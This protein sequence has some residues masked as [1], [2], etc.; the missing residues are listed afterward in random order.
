MSALAWTE[1]VMFA[2]AIVLLIWAWVLRE[3]AKVE[4][5]IA[6]SCA[7]HAA[8][9]CD[10]EGKRAAEVS[11]KLARYDRIRDA[12][13]VLNKAMR[14]RRYEQRSRQHVELIS[15]VRSLTN[16]LKAARLASTPEGR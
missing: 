15:T 1:A 16:E 8:E 2:A 10:R 9:M 11:R 14:E 12:A 7:D 5:A 3:E 6:K 13:R 4:R